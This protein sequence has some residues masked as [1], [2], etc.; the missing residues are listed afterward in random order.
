[1]RIILYGVGAV[2]GTIAAA[3]V[4]AGRDVIG[5]AGAACWRRCRRVQ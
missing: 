4:D 1:M 2:G 5:I 3:L